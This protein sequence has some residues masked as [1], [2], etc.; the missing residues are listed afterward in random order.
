MWG[1]LPPPPPIK[2]K[3]RKDKNIC[4]KRKV[5]KNPGIKFDTR[6]FKFCCFRLLAYNMFVNMCN[7][8]CEYECCFIL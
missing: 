1:F 2:E 5:K 6:E 7:I 4:L 3:I 8:I